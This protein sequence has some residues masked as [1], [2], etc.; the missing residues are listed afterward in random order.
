[1]TAKLGGLSL[2]VWT[3]DVAGTVSFYQKLGFQNRSN[4]DSS[5]DL[6]RDGARVAVM[7]ANEVRP[8]GTAHFGLSVDHASSLRQ[9]F[10]AAGVA[11]AEEQ[12]AAHGS[13]LGFAVRDPNGVQLSFEGLNS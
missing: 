8:H 2:T 6:A 10:T 7:P 13:Q 11:V 4:T 5:G 1:V 3:N 9:E 12:L